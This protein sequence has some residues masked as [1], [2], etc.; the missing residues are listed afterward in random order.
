VEFFKKAEQ[1]IKKNDRVQQ[2]IGQIK[3]KQKQAVHLEHYEKE[4]ALQE[5][6]AHLAE[7]EAELDAI[8]VVQEFKQSQIEVN[9]LLQLITSII[10]NTVTDEIIISTGGNPL[11][12]QTGGGPA[13]ACSLR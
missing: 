7:L 4:K 12:G 2:L 13:E 8:P 10:S 6:D 1:Q 11:T 3:H 5:M 9:D